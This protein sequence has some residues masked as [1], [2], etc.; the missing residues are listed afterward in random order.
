M[1]TPKEITGEFVI[2]QDDSS[3]YYIIDLKDEQ[4]FNELIEQIEGTEDNAEMCADFDKKF[5]KQMIDGYHS[6]VIK[7]YVEKI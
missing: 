3:H 6:I 1:K 5:G 7:S 4:E 2:V